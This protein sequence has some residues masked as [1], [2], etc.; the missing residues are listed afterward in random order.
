MTAVTNYLAMGGYAVF[1]WSAYGVAFAVLG[2]LAVHFWLADRWA[3]R[4]LEHLQSD[5]SNGA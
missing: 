2:G 1:V 3:R 5:G 4:S